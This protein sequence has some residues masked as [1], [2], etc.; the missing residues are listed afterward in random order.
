MVV[1][2]TTACSAE[3]GG[4]PG[5]RAAQSRAGNGSHVVLGEVPLWVWTILQRSLSRA[6]HRHALGI[7]E[8]HFPSTLLAQKKKHRKNARL[9]VTSRVYVSGACV[10]TLGTRQ[11]QKAAASPFGLTSTE[12]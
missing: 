2:H 7:S 9:G 1:A 3:S 12:N 11:L 8:Y 5:C 10:Q 4:S 6:L